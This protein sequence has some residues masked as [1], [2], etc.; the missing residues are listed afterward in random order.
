MYDLNALKAFVSVVKSGSITDSARELNL[1]KSTLSRRIR[2]LEEAVGQPLLQRTSR[3]ITPNEAGRTFYQYGREI[4]QLASH[5]QAALD[6][7]RQDVGGR[8]VL[9][10]HEAFVRNWFARLVESFMTRYETVSVS[11]QTQRRVP[12]Q[13]DDGVCI[14]LGPVG[15]TEF[16]VRTL[17]YLTQGVYG[18]P[19]YFASH[20][21]PS[22]PADLQRHTWVDMLEA[23]STDPVLFHPDHGA[24]PLAPP[25]R[26][27]TVDQYCIQGDAI[28]KGKGLG[29]MPHWLVAQRLRAHPGTLELCLPQWQGPALQ[30]SLLCPHGTLPRRVRV[31]IKYVCESVPG[32]WK[33]PCRMR[34]LLHNPQQIVSAAEPVSCGSLLRE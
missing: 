34:T 16:R 13:L 28:A 19:D 10:C 23:G 31:F 2:Q 30:V 22:S 8:L 18:H 25:R 21:Y 3:Q 4:L 20:G 15:H 17:G 26:S 11:V 32:Q 29:L 14:W 1:S 12:E 6:E 7:L 5:G 24:F 33:E 27:L 9:R